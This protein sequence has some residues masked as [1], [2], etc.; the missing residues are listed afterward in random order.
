MA[1]EGRK[2]K[3]L[4]GKALIVALA[5]GLVLASVMIAL[6]FSHNSQSEFYL[7]SGGI[8]YKYSLGL[9][10]LWFVIGAM[11]GLLMYLLFSFL[12]KLFSRSKL[13]NF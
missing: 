13:N 10:S 12:M 11:G 9:F 1:S 4:K 8:D 7:S 6:G 3:L 5:C 2:M